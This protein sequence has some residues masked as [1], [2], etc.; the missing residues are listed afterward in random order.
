MSTEPTTLD[1]PAKGENG[2]LFGRGMAYMIIW[3]LQLV[4]ATLVSPILTRVLPQSQFGALAATIALYQLL[5]IVSMFGLDQALEIQRVEDDD[6]RRARG[7]LATGILIAFSWAALGWATVRWWGPLLGFTDLRLA[8]IALLWMAPGASVLLVLA[9]LQ[10]EDRLPRFAA[11]SILSTVGG[12]VIGLALLLLLEPDAAQRSAFVYAL[13]GVVAQTAALLL[14]LW[15]CRPRWRGVRDT[16]T[17]RR[18]LALGV[19]LVLAGLA[20]FVL[21]AGDR[22]VV[23][24]ML[25]ADTLA[26]YQVAF[27]VG[28]VTS[29]MLSFTSRAWMPRLK[30]ITRDDARWRVIAEA[31]DGM[32]WLLGWALL[33]ITASAPVLLRVFAPASYDPRLMTPIVFVIG[34]GALPVAAA[35]ATSQQLITTRHPRPIA[36]AAAAAAAVKIAATLLLIRPF[37]LMGAATATAFA[38]GAQALW[39]RAAVTRTYGWRRSSSASLVFLAV[40]GALAAGSTLLPQSLP[41][42]I[43]RFVFS[44][45]C[46]PPF[47]YALR[48]LQRGTGPLPFLAHP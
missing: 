32:Y 30:S 42:L 47:F 21:S 33:G 26:Q 7:L 27:T 4:V 38:L 12:L 18:A 41:W 20:Q 17:L 22:F 31:R 8:V 13:G 34:V 10:A 45:L 36:W 35:A 6:D 14:G 11:V 2:D 37:G 16:D 39:Q 43:G 9:L 46:L 28:N 23:Q 1:A 19:P 3:S 48:A 5:M 44:T 29:L 15:W 25:G 24:R 40:V